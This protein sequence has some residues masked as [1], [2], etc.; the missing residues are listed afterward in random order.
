MAELPRVKARVGLG[1]GGGAPG[2]A[3]HCHRALPAH[4]VFGP[5]DAGS[6]VAGECVHLGFPG[7]STAVRQQLWNCRLSPGVQ[8]WSRA[9]VPTARLQSWIGGHQLTAATLGPL[10]PP[11][12]PP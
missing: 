4:G 9:R 12:L 8:L 1:A 2:H 11:P 7:V 5:S 6:S 3:K 10:G